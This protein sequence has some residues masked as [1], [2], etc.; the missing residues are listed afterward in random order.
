MLMQC[1]VAKYGNFE[2]NPA[3]YQ[4]PVKQMEQVDSAMHT[5]C[6]TKD[7]TSKFVLNVL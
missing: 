1:L 4:Q 2:V 7:C 3:L 6:N 5:G